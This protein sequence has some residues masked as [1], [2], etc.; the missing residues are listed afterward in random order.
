MDIP[1]KM[2]S[3]NFLGGDRIEIVEKDVPVAGPGELLIRTSFCGICG[4]EKRLFHN[5]AKFTP[6]HEMSGVVA[7][8][9][10]GTSM[11]V[12]TR[13]VTYIV[14]YC[15]TC[16]FCLAGE[17]NR[18]LHMDG[19]VG[20]QTHGGY[21]EYFTAPENVFVPLPD[22]VTDEEGVLLLDTI[23]TTLYGIRYASSCAVSPARS[24]KAAVLGCG[25]L[26]LSSVLILKS[27]GWE[28]ISVF[29]PVKE[30]LDIARSWGALP[31]AS[32]DPGNTSQFGLV[33]E[34]SGSHPGRDLSLDLVESGGSVLLLGENDKPWPLPESPKWRRKDCAHV[35]S[36][37]FPLDAIPGH[38]D[39]LRSQRAAYHTLMDKT[40]P[41]EKLEHAFAEFCAGQSLKPLIHT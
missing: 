6:G 16:K 12:G 19:L 33:V 3:A 27:L 38:V 11:A 8:K 13:G 18:C 2:R 26:G 39:F 29:D 22:D 5:G 20:W 36:F 1:K 35:R 31:L 30:R 25:P 41:L 21:A 28:Q 34:A 37:Y 7:G 14:R 4:S 10:P 23:G 17:T 32:D 24:R 40:Y 15:G 9:G